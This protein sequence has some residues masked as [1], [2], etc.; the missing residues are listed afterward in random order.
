MPGKIFIIYVGL[1]NTWLADRAE[2]TT[3]C[4]L[5]EISMCSCTDDFDTTIR[6]G[7]AEET[8]TTTTLIL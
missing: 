3:K 5:Y 8:T 7:V 4:L 1:P 2:D 6:V